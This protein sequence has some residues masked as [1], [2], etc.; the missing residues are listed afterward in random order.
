MHVDF[1]QNKIIAT[2]FSIANCFNFATWVTWLYTDTWHGNHIVI[3]YL[4]YK[5][6]ICIILQVAGLTLDAMMLDSF[7]KIGVQLKKKGKKSM[8]NLKHWNGEKD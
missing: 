6:Y 5:F 7:V 3:L 8:V 1:L 4:Q 2:Y